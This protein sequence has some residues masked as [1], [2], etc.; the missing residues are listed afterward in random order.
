MPSA[1]LMYRC[2]I[3]R[4]SGFRSSPTDLRPNACATA[5]VVPLPAKG[6]SRW[7]ADVISVR[8]LQVAARWLVASRGPAFGPRLVDHPSRRSTPFQI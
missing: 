3:A 5:S 8:R 6:S 1:R 4:Y 2:A 7:P